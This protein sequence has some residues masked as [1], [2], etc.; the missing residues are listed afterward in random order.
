MACKR[1]TGSAFGFGAWY[2]E[3]AVVVSGRATEFVRIGDD[4]G[5]ITSS[6]C[7]IC[8]TTLFW[9]IDTLPGVVAVSAGAFADLTFPTPTVSVYHAS[10]KYPWVEII[11][12]PIEKRG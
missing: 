5:H 7:P 11:A 1:R 3:A 2:R 10:R 4:G 8:G 9:R 6:F 12:V